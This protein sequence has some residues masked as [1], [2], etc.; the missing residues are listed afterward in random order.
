MLNATERQ[1][2][3]YKEGFNNQRLLRT[4]EEQGVRGGRIL[5]LNLLLEAPKP[6]ALAMKREVLMEL[7]TTGE[8]GGFAGGGRGSTPRRDREKMDQKRENPREAITDEY[9]H[10]VF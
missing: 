8:G 10:S 9:Q 3:K 6:G 1:K 4:S 5:A 7:E 2:G